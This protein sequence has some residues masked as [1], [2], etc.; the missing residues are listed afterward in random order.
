MVYCAAF[1]CN[2]NSSKNI[3]T[4]SSFKF[5]TQPTLIKKCLTKMKPA[6]LKST[7]HSRLFSAHFN[8]DTEK[9]ATLV[10]LVLKYLRKSSSGSYVDAINP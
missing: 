1:G 5:H 10:I 3:V 8:R 9:M 6:N 4:R 7:K 2:A